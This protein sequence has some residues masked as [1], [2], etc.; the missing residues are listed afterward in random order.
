MLHQSVVEHRSGLNQF[1]AVLLNVVLHV[2]GNFGIA[3]L[4][5]VVALKVN[6]L[7]ADKVYDA[8]KLVFQANRQFHHVSVESQLFANLHADA[9]RVGSLAVALVDEGDAGYMIALELAVYSD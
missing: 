7:A 5:S 8:F 2:G 6:G 9:K 1:L 3:E 4:V